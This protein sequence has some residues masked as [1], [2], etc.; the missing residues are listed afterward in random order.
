[1]AENYI[2]NAPGDSAVPG[3]LGLGQSRATIIFN[4]F[5]L[6]SYLVPVL[7]A[8]ASDAWLGR[9]KVLCIS[10]RFVDLSKYLGLASLLTLSS[11]YF[12]GTLVQFITSLPSLLD[13]ESGV[14][15][16]VITMVLIGLGVGGTK[17]AITPFIGTV[18]PSSTTSSDKSNKG[19]RGSIPGE[20]L[21]NQDPADRRARD[22]RSNSNLT[23]C[24]QRLLLVSN[25]HNQ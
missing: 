2:Q 8:L 12:C 13:Y 19:I 3:A 4:A 9:Y 25:S 11:L 1:M 10:L 14:A 5:Y 20:A 6:F 23:I 16:L 15:G 17:A 22:H 21:P 24:V 18:L 7:F